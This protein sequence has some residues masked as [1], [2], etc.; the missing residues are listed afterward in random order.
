[1]FQKYINPFSGNVR[2]LWD[3]IS[4]ISHLFF[5]QYEQICKG[6]NFKK[7]QGHMEERKLSFRIILTILHSTFDLNNF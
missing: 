4:G 1:M 6:M 7:F 2:K 3:F 5:S